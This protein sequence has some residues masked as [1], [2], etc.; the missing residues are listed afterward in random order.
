MKPTIV[1]VGRPNV[2]K[3]TLFNKLTRTRDAIVADMPGLTRDRHYGHGRVGDRPYL[4]VDT[5]GLEPTAREGIFEHM[6]RQTLQA[7]AEGDAVLFLVDGRAGITP[8]DRDIARELRRTGRK[9]TLVVNK[10]E[11][12]SRDQAAAEFHE[13]GLGEPHAISATHGDGVSE[14]MSFVLAPFAQEGREPMPDDRPKVAIV[15][16]PNVGKSTLVNA[17]LG[18][19]RMIAFDQPGTTRDSIYIDFER[20]GKPY[21]LIDTAGLRRKAK[22]DETVEKF[23][24]VKTLQSIEDANVVVLVVDAQQEITDQDS[25][26]AGFILEAG[27]AVVLAV[28]KWDDLSEGRREQC[29]RELERKLAFLS[30]ARVHYVSAQ[31]GRGLAELIKS[32]DLAYAAAMAK[33]STP[34]LTRALIAATTRQPPPRHGLFRPKMR[35]AHQ[36]GV[37]PP[38]IVIH[39]NQLDRVPDSYRR[40]L[41]RYFTDLFRLQGTPVRIQFK[42]SANP[43][44]ERH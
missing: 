2:G 33:L 23:S 37:N 44:S 15:G 7:V 40:Y 8:A 6:A 18:E 4:L 21:T 24:V 38:V 28:N 31:Q 16:R 1:L 19:E 43:Y 36:G 5:G 14:L 13:L 9:L 26:I 34:K 11:G 41:E 3:S 29:K 20:A 17:L 25:H 42:V 39:G 10:A 32:I 27:R 22:V 12:L 35:Y 30:F